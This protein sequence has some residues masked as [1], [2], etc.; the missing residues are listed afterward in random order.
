MVRIL[1]FLMAFLPA[2]ALWSIRVEGIRLVLYR[3]PKLVV[4]S[5]LGWLAV[6]AL[7]WTLGRARH[8]HELGRAAL[9]PPLALLGLLLLYLATSGL[10]SWVPANYLYEINQYL[11]L[12][13]LLLLLIVALRYHPSWLEAVRW[14]LLLSLATVTLVGLLQWLDPI[15]WL[16]PIDPELGTDHPSTMGYKNPAALA[17]VGQL[18]LLAEVVTR[19][20]GGRRNLSLRIGLGLLLGLEFAYLLS[21]RSRTA[22]LA[23]AAALLTAFVLHWVR[24]SRPERRKLVLVAVGL[25]LVTTSLLALQPAARQRLATLTPF[26]TNPTS[27]LTSDRGTYLRN[28]L[29]MVRHNPL[30]VGLGDWQSAYPLYRRYDR[31]R[32]FDERFEVRRAHSDY[33][34]FFGE[35]GGPALLLW[36]LFLGLAIREVA[37]TTD[38][39]RATWY[40]A[41]LV[42][43]TVAM[44]TDYLVELPY[45][46]F[47]FFCVL[48]ILLVPPAEDADAASQPGTGARL[49][50]KRRPAV[51]LATLLAAGLAI[52][53]IHYHLQLGHRVRLAAEIEALYSTATMQ[54]RLPLAL[55]RL[56]RFA[57]TWGH[58]KTIYRTWLILGESARRTGAGD[59]ARTC[60]RRGLALHP[61]S[62]SALRAMSRVSAPEEAGTWRAAHD[63]VLDEASQGFERE[64]PELP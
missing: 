10:W 53:Q 43:F 3:E 30:G 63:Y 1:L 7:I 13:P 50:A 41:Q 36:L 40:T 6:V 12:Y 37:R 28:T 24:G 45:S 23:C 18:F 62:P 52:L 54:E 35:G 46:K 22:Y 51:A 2:L 39:H 44:G 60:T 57:T 56:P 25:C 48:A 5:V 42:A 31:Y 32:S 4:L 20:S 11:L 27:Y 47:Q 15:D 49:D 29:V 58:T 16:L 59:L 55:D 8:W 9:R 17:L 33:V 34:Q 21:L 61:F 19:P 38:R 26:V 64:Y 14:G